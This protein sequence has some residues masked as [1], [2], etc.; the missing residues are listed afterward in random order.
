[1]RML[2]LIAAHFKLNVWYNMSIIS[3]VKKGKTLVFIGHVR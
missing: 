3:Q 1:M 2:L